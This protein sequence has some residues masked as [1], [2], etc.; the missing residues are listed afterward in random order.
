[1]RRAECGPVTKRRGHR[2]AQCP[3]LSEPGL[4]Q[5]LNPTARDWKN[6]KSLLA[7]QVIP[8]SCRQHRPEGRNQWTLHLRTYDHGCNKPLQ[9]ATITG[10]IFRMLMEV[11]FD[12]VH[13]RSMDVCSMLVRRLWARQNL[14][15]TK[16]ETG[17][18]N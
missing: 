5:P 8:E 2:G 10:L 4:S 18:Q 14:G 15:S 1:M 6:I 16:V 13:L 11:R 3:G 9:Q 7:T 12:L 17:C